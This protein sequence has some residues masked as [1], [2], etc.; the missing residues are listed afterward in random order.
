MRIGIV[1]VG[2]WG[3][4]VA[5]KVA[6]M[7]VDDWQVR[8]V[9]HSRKG[10]EPVRRFGRLMSTMDLVH[11]DH[12]DV[13]IATAPPGVT[14]L[15]AVAAM[16]LE[17]PILVSKPFILTDEIKLKS[18]LMVDFVRLWSPCWKMLKKGFTD[19]VAS[20]G[21][22][23]SVEVRF[24]G[25]GPVRAFPSIYD[26]GIHVFAFLYD[27]FGMTNPFVLN[28]VQLDDGFVGGQVYTFGGTM[29]DV[30]ISCVTGNGLDGL[31]RHFR[32]IMDDGSFFCY[33]EDRTVCAFVG[34]GMSGSKEIHVEWR[35]DPLGLM[36]ANFLLDCRLG[37][38]DESTVNY[39]RLG[40]AACTVVQEAS[41]SG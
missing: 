41:V 22:P 16:K 37:V 28:K 34:P 7:M 27:L 3:A 10:T 4:K 31:V 32:V 8:V 33:M 14:L 18:P 40:M 20:G 24:G 13:V 11:S 39:S 21:K 19:R 35:H 36:L 2:P 26:Y 38:I 15:A 30:A 23:V 25:K 6:G 17:K 12:V 1:G 9:A 5:D 29:G